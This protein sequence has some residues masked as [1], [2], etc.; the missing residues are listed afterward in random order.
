MEA[1]V[2]ALENAPIEKA[3]V[4]AKNIHTQTV[5]EAILAVKS[6]DISS[7]LSNLSNDQLDIL[8]KYI[9]KGLSIPESFNSASLLSWHEKTLELAGLGSIV[10]V[11]TDRKTV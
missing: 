3:F 9:Y 10:R 1:V 4:S 5:M 8:M 7:V 11:M 6:N 2:K